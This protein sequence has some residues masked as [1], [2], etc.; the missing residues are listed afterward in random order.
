MAMQEHCAGAGGSQCHSLMVATQDAELR[1]YRLAVPVDTAN[2]SASTGQPQLR[3]VLRRG[4]LPLQTHITALHSIGAAGEGAA[5]STVVLGGADGSLATAAA[6]LGPSCQLPV[7]EERA[8]VKEIAAVV[9]ASTAASEPGTDCTLV[10]LFE[11]G[12]VLT[13][14]CCIRLSQQVRRPS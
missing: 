2:S 7:H 8:A 5:A 6:D 3:Q 13:L 11:S 10:V 12:T 4:H 1:Q 14:R 9:H